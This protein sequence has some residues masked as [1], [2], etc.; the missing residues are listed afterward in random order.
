[1]DTESGLNRVTKPVPGVV[2]SLRGILLRSRCHAFYAVFGIKKFFCSVRIS[3]RDSYLRIVC[4]PSPFFSATPSPTPSWTFYCDCAIPFGDSAS[5]DYAACPKAAT[6]LTHLSNVPLQLQETVCQAL[7]NVT[8]VDDGGV[9]ADSP[10]LLS[11]LQ[12]KIG[13]ILKERD[14]HIK[15]W[16]SSGEE[17]SSKYLGMTWR[18]DDQ[19]LLK[20]RLNLYQNVHGIPSREDLDSESHGQFNLLISSAKIMGKAAY[21][22]S[23]SEI[24]IAVLAVKMEWKITLELMKVNLSEPVF[25]GDS[26]IVHKMMARNNPAGLPIF[27]GTRIMEIST[28]SAAV[29]W[30]WCPGSLNPA[31]LLTRSGFTLEKLNSKF[32]LQGSFL[33]QPPSSWPTK[34]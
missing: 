20:F 29:S 2:P 34:P 12:V 5:G 18:K 16:E 21:T 31:D 10:K 11:E 8:D 17:G 25:I 9:G 32:W 14:F 23:Q 13:K 4:V 24:A 3:D 27:Y 30:Y 19:Y 1:M 15:A 22:A 28:L 6:V 26:K 33:P 7:I